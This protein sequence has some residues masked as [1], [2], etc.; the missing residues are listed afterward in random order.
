MPTACSSSYPDRRC[1]PVPGVRDPR[2]MS[3]DSPACQISVAEHPL[4]VC[5]KSPVPLIR[6]EYDARTLPSPARRG[7]ISPTTLQRGLSPERQQELGVYPALRKAGKSPPAMQ[8]TRFMGSCRQPPRLRSYWF[9]QG[10]L[11]AVPT[12]GTA[13]RRVITSGSL[14]GPGRAICSHW[15]APLVSASGRDGLSISVV[16]QAARPSLQT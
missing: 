14:P 6:H 11:R 16:L 2:H 13:S 1:V 5:R 7:T 10:S 4:D 15:Q 3:L 12:H 8:K 9:S